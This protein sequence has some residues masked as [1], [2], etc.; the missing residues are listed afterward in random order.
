MLPVIVLAGGLATRLRPLTAQIPKSLVEVHGEPFLA[1]QL[2]LLHS[3]GIRRVILSVSY[4]GEMI[5]EF[6]GN[7]KQFGLDIQY[8]FDGATFLGTGGAI[9]QALPLLGD[10]FF[11]LYGDSYL[12]CDFVPVLRAFEASGKQGLMTVFHNQGRWDTS[13]VQYEDGKILAY[14]KRQLTSRMR[15]IDY[16]LG[17]FRKEAFEGCTPGTAA[18]LAVVYQDLLRH[19]HLAA[20]EVAER[21]YEIGTIEGLQDTEE[22][23]RRRAG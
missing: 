16:G 4:K 11:T 14:D 10:A 8:S 3:N 15:H 6:A 20:Y 1:H 7:G 18:D 22:F 23:L 5:Q 19:G 17:L 12:T 21:F 9:R 13:N 2:R